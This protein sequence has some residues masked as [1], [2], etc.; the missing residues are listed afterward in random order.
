MFK[1]RNKK[2]L[3]IDHQ[4]ANKLFYGLFSLFILLI[5][6]QTRWIIYGWSMGGHIWE[7][8]LISLYLSTIVLFLAGLFFALGHRQELHFS[9][10]KFLY[11][12]FSYTVVVSFFSSLPVVSFYYLFLIYSAVLFAYL[13]KFLPKFTV[14]RVLLA[15]G[16]IQGLLALYQLMQQQVLSNKWLGMAEHLP[17]NLG[18]AVVEVGDQRL[19][20]AYGSL[21]HP[22]VLGGFLFVVIFLGI[23]LWINVYRRNEKKGWDQPFEKKYLAD[24]LFII[25]GLVVSTYGLLASFSR[26]ALLAL[27]LSLF[28]L[29]LINVFK[30][31]WLAV[32]VFVKYIIIFCL[33]L[34]SFNTWFPGA[35]AVR[36][37]M[38][39]RLEQQSVSERV[40]TYDQLGWSDYKTGFFGQGLG[41][42]TWANYQKNPNLTAYD[43]QPIHDYFI[44]LLAEIGMVGAFLLFNL[45]RLIIKSANQV[46][47]MATSL[48]L[49]LI[50]VGLFDHYL[51]TSWTGWLLVS[52]ALV[53]L[54]KYKE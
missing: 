41:M 28:S 34:W 16:F 40:D 10:N 25:S 48:L 35:W 33:V 23:Y 30:R 6:W 17:A 19:L 26:S 45:V 1:F 39:G 52:L 46:D 5:P 37:H 31:R 42:N 36:W 20:R 8:G 24:F 44:L 54:Y 47:I 12:L 18:T 15:S 32:S 11:L 2:C 13:V 3:G 7:Y 49:G 9:K 27:G 14:F 21:P 51:W 50:V 29:L 22:N 43:I 38:E 53:N 4:T